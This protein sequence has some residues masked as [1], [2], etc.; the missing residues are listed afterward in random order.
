MIILHLYNRSVHTPCLPH[1]KSS[2]S[3]TLVMREDSSYWAQFVS[4]ICCLAPQLGDGGKRGVEE[5]PLKGGSSSISW[6]C[7]DRCLLWRPWR[8]AP[9]LSLG[10]GPKVIPGKKKKKKGWDGIKI[11][12]L[13]L[14]GIYW[15]LQGWPSE[16]FPL[17]AIW[18]RY[19]REKVLIQKSFLPSPLFS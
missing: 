8:G 2:L 10:E 1:R 17:E 3:L 14:S 15:V 4:Q 7:R 6:S 19:F 5:C 16:L 11:R 12:S 13:S 9:C 18:K